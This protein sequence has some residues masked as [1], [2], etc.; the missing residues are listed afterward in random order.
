MLLEK[1]RTKTSAPG[2]STD[3]REVLENTRTVTAMMKKLKVSYN[4]AL[5]KKKKVK[6]TRCG[7]SVRR[8]GLAAHKRNKICARLRKKY[9]K[10]ANDLKKV[11]CSICGTEVCHGKMKRHQRG[12]RCKPKT[13]RYPS[14]L[15]RNK[16]DSPGN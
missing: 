13:R 12:S 3:K 7:G 1:K 6:C 15:K 11:P 4:H 2:F 9:D 14:R 5:E 10:K 16:A 8:D